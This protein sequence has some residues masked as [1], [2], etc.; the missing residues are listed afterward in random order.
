[1]AIEGEDV[2]N[3]KIAD[4]SRSQFCIMPGIVEYPMSVFTSKI[5]GVEA[6]FGLHNFV[7]ATA[8]E[9][10]KGLAVCPAIVTIQ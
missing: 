7:R 1:M 5:A 4:G 3:M 2:M 9:R 8:A 6:L 10:E